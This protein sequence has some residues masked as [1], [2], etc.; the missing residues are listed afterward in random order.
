MKMPGN[1]PIE[2]EYSEEKLSQFFK[3]NFNGPIG[4]KIHEKRQSKKPLYS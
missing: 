3:E 1:L 4:L 2:N